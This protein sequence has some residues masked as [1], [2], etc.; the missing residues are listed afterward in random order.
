MGKV[1]LVLS[2][3]AAKGA[4][5]AGVLLA[6]AEKRVHPDVIVGISSG[7]LNGVVTSN[8]LAS[9]QFT[10]AQVRKHLK[11]VWLR[12]VDAKNFYHCFNPMEDQDDLQTQSLQNIGIRLGIDPFEGRYM[13]RIGL[14]SL[15]A[16]RKLMK[17]RFLGFMSSSFLQGLLEQSLHPPANVARPVKLAIGVCNLSGETSIQADDI[18]RSY[19]RYRQ[20][21]WEAGR[22]P[23]EWATMMDRLRTTAVASA[24][25][26]F[27]FPPIRMREA[28][29][30]GLYVDGGFIE[31]SPI[32]QAIKLDHEVDKVF[33][34]MAA[35]SVPTSDSEPTTILQYISRIFN[36]IA[37]GYLSANYYKVIKANQQIVYL[38][39]VLERDE[40]GN[41]EASTRNDLICR[42]AGLDGLAG[43][44]KRRIVQ[45]IPIFPE[46]PLAGDLFTGM[47]DRKMRERYFDQGHQDAVAV[48]AQKF[49]M[50]RA[51]QPLVLPQAM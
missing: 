30:D 34:V 40:D 38:S 37:G 25:F 7:A 4:Y 20:F 9:G 2:G 51:T 46:V 45:I 41:Y 8:L 15:D 48:L 21:S 43:F 36:I 50:S 1:A 47:F 3:G 19:S 5:E 24:S 11:E 35:T 33:V 12:D 39:Q 10:P 16:L 14:D 6:M 44:L 17:G 49:D 27:I 13:P 29:E 42:A 26:P 22:T 28:G 31:N 23:G 32:S 18:Q